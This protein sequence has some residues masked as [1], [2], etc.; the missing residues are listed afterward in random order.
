MSLE[1]ANP[2]SAKAS[3]SNSN[4]ERYSWIFM[5]VSGLVLVFLVAIQ[6]NNLQVYVYAN[7]KQF[8]LIFIK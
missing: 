6:V 2:R 1:I 4:F 3:R 7:G 5:R 8:I